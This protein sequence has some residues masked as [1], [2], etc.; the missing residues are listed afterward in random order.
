M[1]AEEHL[2]ARLIMVES[3]L[4]DVDRLLDKKGIPRWHIDHGP[5]TPVLRILAMLSE[6]PPKA[7]EDEYSEDETR[8]FD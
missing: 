3:Q 4:Q 7:L 6:L 5:L 2:V 1:N 8:R